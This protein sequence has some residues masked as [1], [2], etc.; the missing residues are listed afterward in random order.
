MHSLKI[1]QITLNFEFGT[2]FKSWIKNRILKQDPDPLSCFM[3]ILVDPD[4]K[5]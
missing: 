4:P 1:S 5:N 3:Q 2:N